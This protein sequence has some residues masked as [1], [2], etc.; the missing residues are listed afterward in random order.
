MISEKEIRSH[1]KGLPVSGLRYFDSVPSTNDEALQWAEAGG[2]DGALV[3]ADEQT[4]GRGRLNRR[5]VT[6]P[7]AALALSLLLHPGEQELGRLLLF[8]PLAALALH[9]ALEQRWGL[10]SQIKW[11]NDVLLAGRKV[12]G[13]LVESAW[14][15][16]QLLGV[17]VGVGINIAPS[18]VP[19]AGE[20]IFPATSIEDQLG[21]PVDRLELMRA[22]LEEMFAWRPRLGSPEFYQTWEDHLAYRGEWVQ[23]QQLG[24]PSLEGIVLGIAPGGNLRLQTEEGKEVNVAAGDV[25]LRPMNKDLS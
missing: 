4:A 25:R 23:I 2:A 9:D 7:G 13:I 10:G 19:P 1:L 21:R 12:A 14:L 5:W 11:P 18:S 24:Q 16:S 15:G 20:L 22:L 3:V 17:V 6:R 8:S